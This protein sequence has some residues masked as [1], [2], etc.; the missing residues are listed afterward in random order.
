MPTIAKPKYGE[1]IIFAGTTG[2]GKST[3]GEELLKVMDSTFVID[4][5]DGLDHLPKHHKVT[6]PNNLKF[7]LKF[8]KKIRYVPSPEYL[9]QSSWNFV[10]KTLSESSSKRKPN[11]RVIYIDEI[12]HI[13]YGT[14]FPNWLPKLATTARQKKLSLWIAAQ[15]PS[16]IPIP[17]MSECTRF[18]IFYLSYEEDI[19]KIAKFSRRR[20]LIE[21]LMNIQYDYS[22][23]ELDRV[24][25]EWRKMPPIAYRKKV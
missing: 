18:Y 3:L 25:G 8:F 23:I 11:P 7:T 16:M 4:T 17:T 20:G 6:N 22:F 10:F 9:H 1:H 14:S 13:G 5:Q 19:K 15:R 21:D 24:K 2:C 12:Y